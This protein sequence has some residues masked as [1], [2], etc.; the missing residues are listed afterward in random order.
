MLCS[1]SHPIVCRR[2]TFSLLS[3]PPDQTKLKSR[4]VL[5]LTPN[6]TCQLRS[7]N[8]ITDIMASF[9]PPPVN[10]IDWSNVGFRVREG[11]ATSLPSPQSPPI[12]ADPS[13]LQ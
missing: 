2:A 8:T 10:T 5:S 1:P 3:Y 12:D 7:S 13:P 9:P 4:R 6:L 11:T